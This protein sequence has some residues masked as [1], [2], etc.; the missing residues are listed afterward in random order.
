MEGTMFD[1]IAN[2]FGIIGGIISIIGLPVVYIKVR[3]KDETL[4]GH[5]AEERFKK[6]EASLPP[7][8]AFGP[9]IFGGGNIK[10]PKLEIR[11]VSY[12][13]QTMD[14]EWKGVKKSIRYF[15]EENGDKWIKG[16]RL[17]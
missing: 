9:Y 2:I 4:F 10:V 5:E 3:A 13:P 12:D 17:K 8:G 7:A 16:W 6:I 15:Y 11:R 14:A 1:I